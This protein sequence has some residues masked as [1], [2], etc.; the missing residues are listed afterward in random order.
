M[1]LKRGSCAAE[2]LAAPPLALA[3]ADDGLADAEWRPLG[4]SGN[5]LELKV[6]I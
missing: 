1:G 2:Q 4:A 6:S 5:E 3:A